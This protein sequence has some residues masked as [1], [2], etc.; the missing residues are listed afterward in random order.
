[1]PCSCVPGCGCGSAAACAASACV[2]SSFAGANIATVGTLIRGYHAMWN[3]GAAPGGE[4]TPQ[5]ED[6]IRTFM[7]ERD[8]E[9]LEKLRRKLSKVESEAPRPPI[10]T[11]QHLEREKGRLQERIRRMEH[12]ISIL[13]GE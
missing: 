13:D 5:E 6:D 8:E 12:E 3:P 4:P 10:R 2:G 9:L 7:R 11:E 1:M